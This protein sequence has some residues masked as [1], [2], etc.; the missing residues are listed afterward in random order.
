[1]WVDRWI[2]DREQS[3]QITEARRKSSPGCVSRA[4]R[5]LD[6]YSLLKLV[7]LLV[8]IRQLCGWGEGG[9]TKKK[10]KPKHSVKFATGKDEKCT[11]VNIHTATKSVFTIMLMDCCYL[12]QQH[13]H[14]LTAGE[15]GG[16][17][18]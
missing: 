7:D 1:M 14:L 4:P 13:L 17:G 18:G 15:G 12:L 16:V 11:E 8:V 5:C 2:L 3:E 10:T 9:G 6:S